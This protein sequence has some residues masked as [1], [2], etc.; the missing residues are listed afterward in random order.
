MGHDFSINFGSFERNRIFRT[1]Q[2]I[3]I[4]IHKVC[5]AAGYSP[6]LVQQEGG[7]KCCVVN[8][9]AAVGCGK[10]RGVY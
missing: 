5:N 6:N 2:K 9:S 1:V 4:P 7:V 8:E 10:M 3:V